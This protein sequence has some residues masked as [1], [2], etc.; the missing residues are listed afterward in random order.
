MS[1]RAVI[2]LQ[3]RLAAPALPQGV[4]IRMRSFGERWMAVAR[5]HEEAQWGLGSSARQALSAA[6]VSLPA[7]TRTALLADLTLLH[8]S[9]EIAQVA[10]VAE[11][12]RPH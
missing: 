9:T 11:Q 7:S 10:R 2:D 4:P 1:R 5:I 3:F 8:P 12:A 6:L